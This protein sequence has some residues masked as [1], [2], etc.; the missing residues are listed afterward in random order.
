MNNTTINKAGFFLIVLLLLVI[1]KVSFCQT[2]PK[3]IITIKKGTWRS[4]TVFTHVVWNDLLFYGGG[5]GS[6]GGDPRHEIEIG[7]FHFLTP[8]SGFHH[9]NNPIITRRQFGLDEPG[10]GITPLSIFDR[11]DSLFMF[12]TSRPHDDLQ[13]RIILI[14]ASIDN[15]YEWSN[16]KIIVD[17]AFS[18]KENNH[19]ASA[20]IDPDDPKNI[21]LYFAARSV[22]DEY[23]I[24]LATVAKNNISS[25]GSYCLLKDYN[26]PVLKRDDAKV[27]YPFIRFIEK[28]KKYELWYSGQTPG[29]PATR[30]CFKT[31]SSK[32]DKFAPA[33]ETI[34]DASGINY[35]NDNAYATGPK[36]Y[37]KNF[38]YSGRKKARGNYISIFYKNLNTARYRYK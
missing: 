35:R 19:G 29:N 15:P 23:R 11:G 22:N 2:L 38:Y 30:S 13:P 12:C 32:K 36:A 21:L 5:S 26:N 20:I 24:L 16:Y 4:A 25:R 9:K 14:S 1:V 34:V 8:D 31:V 10:K 27:N 7:V 33:N 28:N 37:G 17:K 18:G 3:E 6:D